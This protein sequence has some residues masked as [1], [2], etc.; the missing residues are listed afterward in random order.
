MPPIDEERIAALIDALQLNPRIT[1]ADLG[2]LIRQELA[3]TPTRDRP[4]LLGYFEQPGPPEITGIHGP[5]RDPPERDLRGSEREFVSGHSEEHSMRAGHR[6]SGV[7][8]NGPRL[9][10]RATGS[11]VSDCVSDR[12]SGSDSLG[13]CRE[14]MTPAAL[15]CRSFAP[16]CMCA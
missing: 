11:G 10:Y 3:R 7:F 15:S 9:A 1:G 13:K 6:C 2:P 5:A 16:V 4:A 12:D 14:E 8:V